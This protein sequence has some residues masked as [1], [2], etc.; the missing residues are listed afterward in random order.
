M[1]EELFGG[2]VVKLPVMPLDDNVI[3]LMRPHKSDGSGCLVPHPNKM[4][5]GRCVICG[6]PVA[7]WEWDSG[8]TGVASNGET[9]VSDVSEKEA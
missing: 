2:R 1:E 9:R 7:W 3:I 6:E 5:C 4:P 8:C